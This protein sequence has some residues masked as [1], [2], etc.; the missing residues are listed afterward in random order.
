MTPDWLES[1]ATAFFALAFLCAAIMVVLLV[2]R[3]QK[4]WI[5]EVV[6]PVTALYWDRWD[7]RDSGT[8]ARRHQVRRS[9]PS[10]SVAELPSFTPPR[11]QGRDRFRHVREPAEPL[12]GVTHQ[13]SCSV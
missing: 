2:A 13:D 6:W 11:S 3:P 4:M 7:S 1:L 9:A 12:S 8:W 5:M 10:S